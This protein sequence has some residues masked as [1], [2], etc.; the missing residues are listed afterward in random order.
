MADDMSDYEKY[1][2]KK[3]QENLDKISLAKARFVTPPI[4]D[5]EKMYADI[6]KSILESLG[7]EAAKN[8]REF[9]AKATGGRMFS[10]ALTT[11]DED[12]FEMI[13]RLMVDKD[14]QVQLRYNPEYD[15]YTYAAVRKDPKYVPQYSWDPE[16]KLQDIATLRLN[17]DGYVGMVEASAG[18]AREGAVE[19]LLSEATKEGFVPRSRNL[20]PG[21]QRMMAGKAIEMLETPKEE[22]LKKLADFLASG[23]TGKI[24]GAALPALKLGGKIGIPLVGAY[25]SF[26]EAKEAGMSTPEALAYTAAEEANPLPI[27]GIDYFKG[28]ESAAEGRRKKQEESFKKIRELLDK[29]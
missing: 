29:K 21:G 11:P 17:P 5:P 18:G 4:T 22:Y 15:T 27:S 10:R 23:R 7:P 14:R 28:M 2:R 13:R 25:S 6:Q 26:S 19:R 24:W 20:L 3:Y 16:Y 8:P 1:L 9:L 12:T